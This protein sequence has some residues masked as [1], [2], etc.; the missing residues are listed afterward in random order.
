MQGTLAGG[1][2]GG[3]KRAHL[4]LS[5]EA[6][7][8]G[9]TSNDGNLDGVNLPLPASMPSFVPAMPAVDDNAAADAAEDNAPREP[10]RPTIERTVAEFPFNVL[11]SNGLVFGSGSS[12]GS[13]RL[14]NCK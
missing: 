13:V 8:F 12:A 9:V 2:G 6:V 5:M 1:V 4:Q 3:I 7:T 11:P 10:L 14:S